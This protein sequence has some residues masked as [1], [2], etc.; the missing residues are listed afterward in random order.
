MARAIL[1]GLVFS[2][3]SATAFSFVMAQDRPGCADHTLIPRIAGTQIV[4]CQ[5][6]DYGEGQFHASM[7]D[8]ELNLE[9]A[10]GPMTRLVYL[11]P[12]SLSP[13]GAVRNYQKAFADLGTVEEHFSCKGRECFNNLA[14][15][16]VWAKERQME[17]DLG[18]DQYLYHQPKY[19]ADQMYWYGTVTGDTGDYVVS[20]YAAKRSPKDDFMDRRK[21]QA[22]Q[23]FVHL[24]V[25]QTAA[26]EATL[27]VVEADDIT[28]S[29]AETGKI[30]LYGLYFDTG[31]HDLKPDS[32][33]TLGAIAG[34]MQAQPALKLYVV[35]HTDSVGSVDSNQALSERRAGAVVD[36]LVAEHGLDGDRMLPIGVGLAAPVATNATEAGRALNRRVELVQR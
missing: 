31:K 22:G 34:A 4:A 25:V 7:A 5:V 15:I 35:G 36:A 27:E 29:L 16:F 30:A 23:V 10:E 26:F 19:V 21:F 32:A 3:F 6:Q 12:T 1:F 20:V 13:L 14:S 18:V 17:T 28:E 24:D 2:L 8:R 11:G 33:A 9:L